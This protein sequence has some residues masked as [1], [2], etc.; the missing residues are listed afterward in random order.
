MSDL[1]QPDQLKPNIIKWKATYQQCSHIYAGGHICP[2][3]VLSY[4]L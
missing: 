4:A 1:S 3:K 2:Q